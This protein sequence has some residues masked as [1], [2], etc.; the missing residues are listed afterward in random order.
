MLI[1]LALALLAVN[2][3]VAMRRARERGDVSS[4]IFVASSTL[5][6]IALLATVRAHEQTGGNEAVD[7]RRRG[8]LKAV[9]W[10]LSTVLT[11]M[12]AHR[13][14]ALAPTATFAALIWSMAAAT[15]CGGFFFL[16]VHGRGD[17]DAIL[18]ARHQDAGFYV[19]RSCIGLGLIWRLL[20]YEAN[21]PSVCS[22]SAHFEAAAMDLKLSGCESSRVG[23]EERQ[24]SGLANGKRRKKCYRYFK[25]LANRDQSD[26][27]R[28]ASTT[29]PT[30]SPAAPAA[31]TAARTAWAATS[32]A[33]SSGTRTTAATAAT[34]RGRE[35]DASTD[36]EV[37]AAVSTRLS[38]PRSSALESRPR[39]SSEESVTPSSSALDSSPA[40]STP[41]STLRRSSFLNTS[42]DTS[43][44]PSANR[45]APNH[46]FDQFSSYRFTCISAP[47]Q[48][49]YSEPVATIANSPWTVS[50]QRK[51]FFFSS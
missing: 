2:S 8:Q 27:C 28:P 4:S 49:Y 5:L 17:T 48:V 9:A 13:V 42:T 33:E 35:T 51:A 14:A 15:V 38:R 36:G 6:L 3:C 37:A 10:A 11:V 45:P 30:N 39:R 46:C 34:S 32:A 47:Q 29:E 12:F 40:F 20:M 16:F 7:R 21:A 44:L 43:S 19:K 1:A 25:R 18:D 41:L 26:S 31:S 23:L 22:S 24:S 50:I